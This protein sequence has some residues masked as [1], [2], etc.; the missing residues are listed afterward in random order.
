M[1]PVTQFAQL[2]RTKFLMNREM[3][4]M[5]VIIQASMAAG[6]VLG[7]GYFVPHIGRTQAMFITAGAATQ[8]V[9]TLG[10]VML[11]QVMSQERA[12]GLI[13]YFLTLPV[14]REAYLLAEIAFIA[15][16]TLPGVAFA[17][18][19]GAWHYHLDLPSDP[20]VVAVTLLT[21]FS[22]TGV[23]VAMVVLVPHPQLVNVATQLIIF[24]V[25]LFSPVMMP[26]EQLPA[27]LRSISSVMPT[28]YAADAMRATLTDLPG[29]HFGRAM[30]VLL[31]YCV[32]SLVA[33]AVA[34]RRRG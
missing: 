12:E 20:R 22:L 32:V 25:L 6:M 7:F 18:V 27:A 2:L 8:V 26:R 29:T 19:L 14:S 5:M 15:I 4:A 34:I 23:G 28:T 31:G 16:V 10:L 30:L 17:V 1:S 9:I 24:W 11:P 3:L 13:E 33:S 21:L